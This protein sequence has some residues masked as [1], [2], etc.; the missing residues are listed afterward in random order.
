MKLRV[1]IELFQDNKVTL[2]QA[3]QI[4]G[5]HQSQFQKEI[6]R[7]KIPIHYDIDDFEADLKTLNIVFSVR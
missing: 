4:A 3:S 7:R 1:A 2:V 5:L 6:A